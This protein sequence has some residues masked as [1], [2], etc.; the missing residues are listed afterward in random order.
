MRGLALALGLPLIALAAAATLQQIESRAIALKSKG[1]A[2]GA[3]AAYEEAAALDPK[4]AMA[5]TALACV[6]GI[7]DWN[8]EE[9]EH[10]FKA[11]IDA[12][13]NYALAHHWYALPANRGRSRSG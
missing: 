11:A 13:P 2:A 1:D 8:W 12:D 10:G 3:L 5:Q 6:Q 4:S 9:A 7:C